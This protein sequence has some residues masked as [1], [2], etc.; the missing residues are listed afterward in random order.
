MI[1]ILIIEDERLAANRLEELIHSIEP[2]VRILAVLDTVR[3]SVSWLKSNTAD[4]VFMDINL[5]DGISFDIFKTI[6]LKTP[7]IFTTAYDEYALKAFKVNSIDYLLKPFSKEDV[8]FAIEKYRAFFKDKTENPDLENLVRMLNPNR[9]YQNRFLVSAGSLM[10]SL[11]IEEIAYFYN[12]EKSTFICTF[13]NHHYA[14]GL[15]LDKLE[16]LI[17]PEQFFRINRNFLLGFKSIKKIYTLSKSRIKLEIEPP[18]DQ[19]I[20]VSFNKSGEFRQWLG[21]LSE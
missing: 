5:S 11:G 16:M 18:S 17:N 20:L 1:S 9:Q 14:S 6:D 7:V 19:D 15:S 10:K 21:K 12:L 2:S 4:L 13:T 3:E 8:R